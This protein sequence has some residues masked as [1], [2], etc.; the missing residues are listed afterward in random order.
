MNEMVVEGMKFTGER[1]LPTET[2]DIELEHNHRYLIAAEFA[3]GKIVLD[4]ASGEGYGSALLAR[5]ADR[6]IGVDISEQAVSHAQ[7]RYQAQNLEYR[8]GDGT[9]IPLPD[10]SVDMTV[11]FETLEHLTEHDELLSEIKRVLKPHG[12]LIMSSPDKAQYSDSHGTENE[13]HVRE[14]YRDEFE[15]LLSKNFVNHA[16]QGQRIVYGSILAAEESTKSPFLSFRNDSNQSH[17]TTGVLEAIYLVAFASDGALP[18]IPD[19]AYTTITPPYQPQLDYLHER[20]QARANLIRSL[21]VQISTAANAI[22]G[23]SLPDTDIDSIV[24]LISDD[25][26]AQTLIA[27]SLRQ[28]QDEV[29]SNRKELD[30]AGNELAQ[31]RDQISRLE[32]ELANQHEINA[33]SQR[34]ANVANQHLQAMRDSHSWRMTSPLRV[35]VNLARAGARKARSVVQTPEPL[36]AEKSVS[37]SSQTITD[38]ATVSAQDNSESILSRARWYTPSI[39]KS[40]KPRILILPGVFAVGGV[41]RLTAAI[42]RQLIEQFQFVIVSNEP[43]TEQ[44]GCLFDSV[45]Q[46]SEAQ[47]DLAT[48]GTR[49]THLHLLAEICQELPPD[50]IWVCNGSVW[51]HENFNQLTDMFSHVPIVDQQVY[52]TDAGWINHLKPAYTDRVE[53]MIAINA[54]IRDKF[55]EMQIPAKKIDLI[56]SAIDLDGLNLAKRDAQIVQRSQDERPIGARRRYAFVAR[57]SEQK[58]PLDFINAAAIIAGGDAPIDLLMIGDGP[59]AEQCRNVIDENGIG[60]ITLQPFTD[61]LHEIYASVDGIVFVSGYEGLPLVMLEALSSGVP[62]LAT[63]VGD[64]RLVAEQLDGGCVVMDDAIG[65]PDQIAKALI[66]FDKDITRHQSDAQRN[67]HTVRKRFGS[68]RVAQ[69]YFECWASA[70]Q[71]YADQDLAK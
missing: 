37:P 28:L 55:L 25:P 63:D 68:E 8:Q 52:D 70:W 62:V 34:Q 60:N 39:E 23:D 66:Q 32:S 49:D 48:M 35:S 41:E 10:A 69:H 12:L 17:R 18:P 53:R 44:S 26:E 14:L 2:G 21:A 36:L 6:V 13:F 29:V 58:R 61:K 45:T 24:T 54:K 16:I 57:F 1:F 65:R 67:R 42:M 71:A 46:Y 64:I 50:L 19:S 51:F 47:F 5:H 27:T 30:V 3:A 15:E 33:A 7:S 31:A 22:A 59:L 9:A 38:E 11:S 43:H 56:Y 40:H 20:L 4:I